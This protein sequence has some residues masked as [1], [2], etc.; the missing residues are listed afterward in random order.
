ML[1]VTFSTLQSTTLKKID[2]LRLE[3][4]TDTALK[5]AASHIFTS[6]MFHKR[7]IIQE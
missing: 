2:I 7:K 4:A 1:S 3:V 6:T 5:P